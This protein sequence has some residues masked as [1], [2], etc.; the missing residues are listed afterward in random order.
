[1]SGR[2]CV[3]AAGAVAAGLVVVVAPAFSAGARCMLSPVGDKGSLLALR[4]TGS[5]SS[6]A[7]SEQGAPVEQAAHLRCTIK[8]E[9]DSTTREA[10]AS[11]S[12][13]DGASCGPTLSLGCRRPAFIRRDTAWLPTIR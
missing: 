10:K 3:A 4:W 5:C 6:F 12:R 7:H 8:P 9:V 2:V 11:A 13:S 1:M